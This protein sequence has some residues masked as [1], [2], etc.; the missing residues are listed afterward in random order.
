MKLSRSKKTMSN[1]LTY[2]LDR[3]NKECILFHRIYLLRLS[4]MKQFFYTLHKIFRYIPHA[5]LISVVLTV[6]LLLSIQR[7]D[8]LSQGA[9]ILIPLVIT[10]LILLINQKKIYEGTIDLSRDIYYETKLTEPIFRKIYWILFC[11]SFVWVLITNSR[12]I[13]FIILLTALY[14]VIILEI[15][16]LKN[17]NKNA[18]L[19]QIIVAFGL[20]VYTL[21]FSYPYYYGW[22]DTTYHLNLVEV[23]IN[24]VGTIPSDIAGPYTFFSL[25]HQIIAETSLITSLSLYASLY[26]SCAIVPI[27][28]TLFI[29][30]IASIFTNN[31]RIII[32]S[33]LLFSL[34]PIVIWFAIYPMPRM[35]ASVAFIIILYLFVNR[36]NEPAIQKWTICGII[37]F[38]MTIVHHAQLPLIFF[39]M[40]IIVISYYIYAG[41]LTKTQ[42]GVVL[43]FYL[44]P[45]LY[46]L[47]TYLITMV[48]IVHSR[49]L[50][51]LNIGMGFETVS[52]YIPSFT[53][54][55]LLASPSVIIL[56]FSIIGLYYILSPK[57]ISKMTAIL[58]PIILLMIIFYIPYIVDLSY[59]ISIMLQVTRIRFIIAPFFAIV[60]AFGCII[61]A[62]MIN[63]N[64]K[65]S[66]LAIT[67]VVAL[68]LAFVISSPILTHTRDSNAFDNTSIS[69]I[70]YYNDNDLAMFHTISNYVPLGSTY[71]ADTPLER[72]F[73]SNANY[74]IFDLPYYSSLA[75]MS[76]FFMGTQSLPTD[77]YIIFR[78]K[79]YCKFGLTLTDTKGDGG[80]RT[81]V[82]MEESLEMFKK[83]LY[84]SNDIYRNGDS[85]IY[86]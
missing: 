55:W 1:G 13:I 40:T 50:Q 2:R 25:F 83:N 78:E 70:L 64:G 34:T 18:I 54:V 28:I 75:G 42:I 56:I 33:S 57:Q 11:T 76:H 7:V 20:L 5:A 30:Y 81:Y 86:Y 8:L 72:Y 23:L 12:D 77:R 14:G 49:L 53:K 31:N 45:A 22:G 48:G 73:P 84:P 38:Y 74:G 32:V 19:M 82:P 10:S 3:L 59:I 63:N 27:V 16:T 35:L 80:A 58:C 9:I 46:W 67:V 68:C 4:K 79:L 71:Y 24:N 43:L 41:K 65:R 66:A 52:I 47:Y 69:E 61:L 60:M 36:P 62:N 29:P 51:P 39:V 26:I 15:F 85:I 21:V 17:L 37:T 44:I 6:G